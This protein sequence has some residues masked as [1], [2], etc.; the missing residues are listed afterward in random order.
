MIVEAHEADRE[1]R[2]ACEQSKDNKVE[3]KKTHGLSFAG[4]EALSLLVLL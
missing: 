2:V 4:D 3:H 1:K